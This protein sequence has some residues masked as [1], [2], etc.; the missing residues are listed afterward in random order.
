MKKRLLISSVLMSAVLACALGT[1]TYAWYK[2]DS[3]TN[4][5]AGTTAKGDISV[6]GPAAVSSGA[7]GVT[8]SAGLEET[9]AS[10]D[11]VPVLSQYDSAWKTGYLNANDVFVPVE[12]GSNV[13]YKVYEVK[14]TAT[15]S[16]NNLDSLQLAELQG[17]I[18]ASTE[19][20]KVT[21]TADVA[22]TYDEVAYNEQATIWTALPSAAPAKNTTAPGENTPLSF[23]VS[24]LTLDTPYTIGYVC[25]YIDGSDGTHTTGTTYKA[26]V[27]STITKV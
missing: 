20:W 2:A 9:A 23:N 8:I 15:P 25:V 6:S 5:T 10:K 14:V 18:T 16:A 26:H 4:I 7:Y 12:I 21:F 24:A 1:G 17:L 3:S 13:F 22:G 19:S 27:S 11:L